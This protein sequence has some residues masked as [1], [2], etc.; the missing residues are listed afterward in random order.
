MKWWVRQGLNLRPP[1]CE[2]D[3]LPLSYAPTPAYL[4]GVRGDDKR[5]AP[6]APLRFRLLRAQWRLRLGL[7]AESGHR[8]LAGGAVLHR[9]AA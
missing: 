7:F 8:R 6:S 3:A 4:A 5:G 1:P 9:H 2:G